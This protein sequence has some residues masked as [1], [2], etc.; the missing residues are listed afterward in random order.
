MPVRSGI[1]L[2]LLAAC[3]GAPAARPAPA[4]GNRVVEMGAFSVELP[5]GAW[6]PTGEAA[7][8]TADIPEV[9]GVDESGGGFALYD[10]GSDVL[11]RGFDGRSA[12]GG[13]DSVALA[14]A[15]H[16]G[17][18]TAFTSTWKV[19]LADVDDAGPRR[20]KRYEAHDDRGLSM[21]AL[22]VTDVAGGVVN[23]A[24]VQCVW[25]TA[26]GAKAELCRAVLASLK[27]APKK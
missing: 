23:G 15:L 5:P 2:L 14:G 21:L 4:P 22:V 16:A 7:M 9:A 10:P 20:R 18:E 6:R 12:S 3:G 25:K 24:G 11:V 26:E 19:T 27:R 1:A 8:V 13:G 17:A